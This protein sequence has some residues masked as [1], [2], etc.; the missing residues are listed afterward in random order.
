MGIAMLGGRT[1]PDFID[2]G[3]RVIVTVKPAQLGDILCCSVFPMSNH[4]QLRFGIGGFE[5]DLIG[6]YFKSP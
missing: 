4:G 5:L 3:D 6:Y 2:R 1:W